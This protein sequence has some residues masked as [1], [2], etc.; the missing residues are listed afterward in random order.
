KA[1]TGPKYSGT[2]L[3][4]TIREVTGNTLFSQ[5]LTNIV[6]PSFDIEKL[7]PT[8]FSSYQV[9]HNSES[10]NSTLTSFTLLLTIIVTPFRFIQRNSANKNSGRKMPRFKFVLDPIIDVEEI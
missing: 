7:Q 8:I 6:I 4:K 10:C 9:L 1:L 2:Y 3:H 5:T